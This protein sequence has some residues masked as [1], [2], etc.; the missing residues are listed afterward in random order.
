MFDRTVPR[1]V[2]VDRIV[3]LGECS[4]DTILNVS[5][6]VFAILSFENSVDEILVSILPEASKRQV[7]ILYI[8][9]SDWFKFAIPLF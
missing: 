9:L 5:T 7:L 8:K 3:F 6:T 2:L 4:P 1:F